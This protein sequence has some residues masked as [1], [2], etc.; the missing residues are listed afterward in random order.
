M[1]SNNLE[2][3]ASAT[4]R[5]WAG[6][7]LSGVAIALPSVKPSSSRPALV[8]H[9]ASLLP[10]VYYPGNMKVLLP[11]LSGDSTYHITTLLPLPRARTIHTSRL[12]NQQSAKGRTCYVWLWWQQAEG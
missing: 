3:A 4:L 11:E 7:S 2:F 8:P 12:V 1:G 5:T 6:L 9:A 10:S